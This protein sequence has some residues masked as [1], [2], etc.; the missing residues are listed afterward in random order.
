[1]KRNASQQGISLIE[2]LVVMVVLTIGILSA[3]RL[4]P[5]GFFINKQTEA[6]TLASRL[7]AQELGRYSTASATLMD[8]VLP[9]VIVPDASS[10]TGYY[11]R[12]DKDVTPD[13]LGTPSS[14]PPGVDPYYVSGI[15]RIRW[16]RGETVR[17]PNPSP[18][19]GGVRGS[20]YVLNS[21]PAFD[22]PGLD[23]NNVPID[24]IV[25]TGAPLRRRAQSSDD[26]NGPYVRNNTEYAIDYDSGLVGFAAAPYDRVFK[27]TYSY[28]GAGGEVMTVAAAQIGVAASP[29]P[30]WQPIY[31]PQGRD[32]VPGS[33][34]ISRAFVRVPYP[35]SFSSDP[36]E[37]S[38][39]PR[40]AMVAP[41]ATVGVLIFNPI[42]R[43]HIER[44]AYGNTPLTARID[45]N[46]LDWHII[47]EDRSLPGSAP[48]KV[49]LTLKNIKQAGEYESD[50]R[51]YTGIWR[52]ADAPQ[53]SVLIY[54]LATGEEV[55]ASAY[56]VDCREGMVT[57]SDAFGDAYRSRNESPV[58]RFY[59]KAHNDWGVQVQKAASKYTMSIGNTSNLGYGDFYL[60]GGA[61]GGQATR[62]YFP[63]MEAGKSVSIRELWYY[64]LN[65]LTNTVTL[66]KATNG[67]Y[68][69]NADPSGF[70]SLGF[71]PMTWLDL[72]DN[73]HSV[74]DQAVGWA[75]DQPVVVVRGVEGLS[76]K[77]RVV[78]NG[79]SSV[80]RSGGANVSNLRWRRNDLD[81]F[82]TRGSN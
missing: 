44:S 72:Q 39:L 9:A 23:A 35:P 55:P 5:V 80:T 13:D 74:T 78:W 43:D 76:F 25:V 30:V 64:S 36:Y 24:S 47:R 50:Q 8:A 75:L 6:R 41:F 70:E 27:V 67:T 61:S 62:M 22:Y 69:I 65:S 26:P 32:I 56:T 68:R 59:Y 29:Y 45:Y 12:V 33:E 28:Y 60:G 21:G 38:L 31:P 49:R 48:Y 18:L 37:Y 14:T 15:N 11:I 52:S 16:I 17:I 66:R 79:G 57:F 53:V 46:V 3:V 4:F 71:G 34:T 7:A 58:F 42:G 54:N 51:K 82:L 40:S 81:T 20:V 63:L 10:P 1:M 19:G 77:V 2:V 73:H